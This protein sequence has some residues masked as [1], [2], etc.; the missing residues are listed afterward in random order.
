VLIAFVLFGVLLT[1]AQDNDPCMNIRTCPEC[2]FH[3]FC[4]WCSN[5]ITYQDGSRGKNCAWQGSGSKPFVCNGVYQTET[6]IPE[7]YTCDNSTYSCAQTPTGEQIEV[8]VPKC[9][10]PTYF[11]DENTKSCIKTLNNGSSQETCVQTCGK[12]KY[13]CDQKTLTCQESKTGEPKEACDSACGKA[14]NITPDTFPGKWRGIQVSMGYKK[15]EWRADISKEAVITITTPDKTVWAKG[16]L[17]EMQNELWIVEEGGQTRRSLYSPNQLPTTK[18]LTWAIGEKGSPPPSDFES[19]MKGAPGT[20]FVFWKCVNEGQNC[21][22]TQ[23]QGYADSLISQMKR[24]MGQVEDACSIHPNCKECIGDTVNRCGWCSKNVI[25]KNGSEEG[26]QCAGHNGDGTKEPFYCYGTYSTKTCDVFTTTTASSTTTT[27]SSGSGSGS[28]SGTGKL[29]STTKGQ[30]KYACD[31]VTATCKEGSSGEWDKKVD[32]D[33]QCKSNPFVPIDLQGVWRG[34]Q[35]NKNYIVGE[36]RAVFT[37]SNVTV[38][39]PDGEK[40][41][42]KCYTVSTY[43]VVEPQSGPLAGKK[44]STLWQNLMGPVTKYLTWAWGVPGGAPPKN[45]D[46]AMVEANN[47]EFVMAACLPG[48]R[49][50]VCNFDH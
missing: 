31:P 37:N 34:L 36:W 29:S 39:R 30:T 23:V 20:V 40:F 44:I 7:Y 47:A 48:S 50:E 1:L 42:G 13:T 49:K 45:Y 3:K 24:S 21:D 41:V 14:H 33:N 9:V 22:F 26:K 2:V 35:I 46:S 15:G 28:G 4:G 10:P 5:P 12:P 43:L 17:K 6:C 18:V 38:T 19:A 32:C 16:V 11:C 27:S 8:C 25:Y